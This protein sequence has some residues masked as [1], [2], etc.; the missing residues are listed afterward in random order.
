MKHEELIKHLT[1]VLQDLEKAQMRGVQATHK[2]I[3]VFTASRTIKNILNDLTK[4]EANES[5]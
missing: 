4:G 5:N 3:L 1:D 2:Q